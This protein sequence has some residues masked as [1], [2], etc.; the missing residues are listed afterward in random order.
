MDQQMFNGQNQT[1]TVP[2]SPVSEIE[3]T[4][5]QQP[6]A[7]VAKKSHKKFYIG[8]SIIVTAYLLT[9]GGYLAYQGYYKPTAKT[10]D[11]QQVKTP[12]KIQAV[13][14]TVDASASVLTGSALSESSLTSTDDSSTAAEASTAASNVG[15]G[16]NENNF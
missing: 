15:D 9:L 4:Q 5:P 8:T 6:V 16:V 14:P 3:V 11:S 1:P 2:I 12:A 7:Q 13:N 10:A